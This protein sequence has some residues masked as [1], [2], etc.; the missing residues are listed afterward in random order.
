MNPPSVGVMTELNY[1]SSRSELSSRPEVGSI[2]RV[3]ERKRVRDRGL[4]NRSERSFVFSV[5]FKSV[6]ST[7]IL[8]SGVPYGLM[9]ELKLE[10]V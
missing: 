6:R 3:D 1:R 9:T 5:G 2:D 8:H 7:A 10:D 4:K